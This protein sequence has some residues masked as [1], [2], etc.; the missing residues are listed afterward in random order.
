MK[1]RILKE[2]K[3]KS[4]EDKEVYKNKET[5]GD[6]EDADNHCFCLDALKLLHI[7]DQKSSGS[8]A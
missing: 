5:S 4:K 1:R 3:K 7:V 8:N 6:E 2:G